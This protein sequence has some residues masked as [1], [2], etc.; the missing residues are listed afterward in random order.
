MF[1][2]VL[3]FLF[4][5]TMLFT[6]VPSSWALREAGTKNSRSTKKQIE[7]DIGLP[8]E[9][10]LITPVI[11]EAL[12]RIQS[13]PRRP[14]VFGNWK[15]AITSQNDAMELLTGIAT[16]LTHLEDNIDIGIA[17]TFLELPFIM[18]ALKKMEGGGL[19]VDRIKVAAQNMAIE[20]DGALTGEISVL[21][22]K[23]LGVKYVILGHSERR[24]GPAAHETN[25]EI[26]KKVHLALK[27]GLTPILCVGESLEEREAGL[28]GDVLKEQTEG[29]LKGVSSE[30]AFMSGLVI[31]YE[32]VWAIGTGVNATDEQAEEA[33]GFIRSGISAGLFGEFV[34]SQMRIQYG[35]SV[36][37]N[38]IAG[39]IA[40]P[41]IDG[42]LVGGASL[43]AES[44]AGILAPASEK[45]AEADAGFAYAQVAPS[46]TIALESPTLRLDAKLAGGAKGHFVVPAGSSTG[47]REAATLMNIGGFA[48]I[49]ESVEKIHA[50]VLNG[51]FRPYQ[52]VEIAKMM[53]QMGKDTLGAEAT[54]AY[55]MA[56]AWAA[57]AQSGLQNYEFIRKLAPDLASFG[58]PRTKIQYNITNGGEHADNDLDM[59]EFMIVTSGRTTAEANAMADK[60]DREL[61][62]IYQ[63][64]GLKADP[65][66]KGMGPLRGKEGGYAIG[67]LTVKKLA[68]IYK[69]ADDFMKLEALRNLDIKKLAGDN[70]GVHEFVLNALIAAIKNAGYTPSTSGEVGTV[71][72]AL[73]AASSSMLVE[74]H[75]NLYNYEGRQI[76]SEELIKIYTDWAKKYP[77]DSLEDGLGEDDW[78]GW[79][80]LIA[81]I[82]DD[83]LLIGDDLL[84]TQGESLAKFIGLLEQNGF[85]TDGKVN[86]RLAILI[87]LNQNGF[88]TTGIND[89]AKGYLGTLEVIRLAK[90]YGIEW[91]VSHRSKEAGPEDSEVSIADL[92]AG[93]N[94]YAL[95]SGDHVQAIRAVKEDRLA[96]IDARERAL[97]QVQSNI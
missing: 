14:V 75:T 26:N 2:K 1:T 9:E 5:V 69:Y 94:A 55:Q 29:S 28:T 6:S 13:V 68:T 74:G 7:Q 44:Y 67:D 30:Q 45:A 66:D 39:L 65:D 16:S 19:S 24:R 80:K 87:K 34:A 91:V 79:M 85:I 73:D 83:I 95:K 11:A 4:T 71:A 17:P 63:A 27:H 77:I 48:A 89:L 72:L 49:K 60:V 52:L 33:T 88:L 54:L 38:N 86:K 18:S 43:D 57:A 25:E 92:A 10:K 97:Q 78:D 42:A 93:T 21:R 53:L 37:P 46:E 96:E 58:V 90:K 82:G 32:P 22:L 31:A 47:W 62:F 61:G 59:Q 3:S 64:L 70:I 84:V 51:R 40:Q 56:S 76:S 36:K 81:A 41:N 50:E 20:E 15:M 35:G 8:R 12:E 23:E